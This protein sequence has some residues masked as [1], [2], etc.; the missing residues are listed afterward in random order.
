MKK[1]DVLLIEDDVFEADL[2]KVHLENHQFKI[3]AIATNLKEALTYYYIKK[4]DVVIVDIFLNQNPDGITFAEK[5]NIHKQSLKPFVFLTGHMDRTIFERAKITQPY[6]FLLKP[7]NELEIIY[8]LELAL[9]KFMDQTK[10]NLQEQEDSEN[11][12]NLAFFVKKNNVLHKIYLKDIYY[13]EVEGRYSKIVLKNESFLV[14]YALSEL[15][16][17]LPRSIFIRSHRNYIVNIAT[18]KEIHHKDNLILLKNQKQIQLGRTYKSDFLN[19]YET[20]K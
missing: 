5:I 19:V 20:L 9:E 18:V 16:E 12:R 1:I 13:I 3:V 4:F 10:W 8:A 17:K 6:S 14:Q 7:F 2:L 15:H 11:K